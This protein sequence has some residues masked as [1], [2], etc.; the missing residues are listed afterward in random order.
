MRP[1]SLALAA[2][3]LATTQVHASDPN[4][5]AIRAM[6]G[7]PESQRS[8]AVSYDVESLTNVLDVRFGRASLSFGV[9]NAFELP[10]HE[11]LGGFLLHSDTLLS[12]EQDQIEVD[13][14]NE[15]TISLTFS[16][17]W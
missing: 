4:G 8:V 5:T 11:P 13:V 6:A 2:L 1:M 3:L 17:S 10:E 16:F 9:S 14:G 12:Q 7:I 15:R